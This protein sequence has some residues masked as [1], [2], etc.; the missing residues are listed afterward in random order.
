[1]SRTPAVL[2]VEDEALVA[3]DIADAL[4]DAGMVVLG[5]A[6][7]VADALAACRERLPDIA[8]LD[9]NLGRE[10]VFPVADLLHE[11]G[12]PIIFHSGAQPAR[13]LLAQY[14]G[15]VLHEKPG[16]PAELVAKMR[17]LL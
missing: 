3:M 15:A 6:A 9:V 5:P 16:V 8:V 7:T 4:T 12:V 10:L 14:R 17:A 13:D 2:I 1:M 11:S